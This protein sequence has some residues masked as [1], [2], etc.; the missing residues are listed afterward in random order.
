MSVLLPPEFLMG[1]TKQRSFLPIVPGGVCAIAL[2]VT[3]KTGVLSLGEGGFS[4][5]QQ[6]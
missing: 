4:F 1:I 6:C 5:P 2:F 3:L